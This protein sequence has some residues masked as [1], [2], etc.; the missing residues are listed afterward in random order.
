M[1]LGKAQLPLWEKP[2][3]PM[4]ASSHLKECK[5]NIV[6]LKNLASQQLPQQGH[7]EMAPGRGSPT[8]RFISAHTVQLQGR[9]HARDGW[10]ARSVGH[11]GVSAVGQQAQGVTHNAHP[12]AHRQGPPAQ[13]PALTGSG[14]ALW[15]LVRAVKEERPMLHETTQGVLRDV[16]LG[17]PQAR[18][19]PQGWLV[20][21]GGGVPPSTSEEVP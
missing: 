11:H 5:R 12:K 3:S 8:G 4:G 21:T 18:V 19:Q 14:L 20:T 17:P 15:L 10:T 9:R 2:S 7:R 1:A 13:Q 6:P 16:G